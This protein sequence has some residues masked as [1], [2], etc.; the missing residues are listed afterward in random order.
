MGGPAAA[1]PGDTMGKVTNAQHRQTTEWVPATTED[2]IALAQAKLTEKRPDQFA[3]S[4]GS[5]EV[6]RAAQDP[7]ALPAADPQLAELAKNTRAVQN[8]GR[9]GKSQDSGFNPI[10][11]DQLL[12]AVSQS[13][14]QLAPKSLQGI[15][16]FGMLDGV[17][18]GRVQITVPLNAGKYQ[19][20]GHTVTVKPGTTA[21][22]NVEVRDG[23]VVP[24]QGGAGTQVT[25]DPPI[26]GPIGG[27]LGIRGKGAHVE[28]DGNGR[29]K[30]VA[31]VGGFIG[32]FVDGK[33]VTK[34]TD[35]G[36][37]TG[38]RK[39]IEEGSK[40]S[41]SSA[42]L[43]QG[44][45]AW[46]KVSFG[47]S[48]VTLRDNKVDLGS[49]KVDLGPDSK[50]K[51][52]GNA[53]KA[54]LTGNINID[55]LSLEQKG[56]QVSGGAGSANI[57]VTSERT[58]DGGYD[59]N[60]SLS[61]VQADVTSLRATSQS[62]KSASDDHLELKGAKLRDGQVEL[63]AHLNPDG[64]VASSH[65]RTRGRVDADSG[66]AQLTVP[67]ANGTASLR[68][69][70][71]GVSTRIDAS[72]DRIK[73]DGTATG[74]IE[75]RGLQS[76]NGSSSID[77][78]HARAAGD[79]SLNVDTAQ[80]K[81]TSKI[82]A[83]EID[84]RLDDYRGKKDGLSADIGRTEVTGT[85]TLELDSKK[86][87]KATGDMQV[88]GEIDD[89]EVRQGGKNKD[90]VFRLAQGSKIDGRIR[91]L[92]V[93]EANGFELD[94]RV[95]VDAKL[96]QADVNLPGIRGQGDGHLKGETDLK[97]G[98][99]EVRF[100]NA[101]ARATLNIKDGHLA[102]SGDVFSADLAQGKM[103]LNLKQ[104]SYSSKSDRV[105][106]EV[107]KGSVVE[108]SLDSG[109]LK[110]GDYEM[111]LEKGSRARMD[112]TGMR[113][114]SDGTPE[115]RG[116]L[117]L[118]TKGTVNAHGLEGKE[119]D[120]LR[121]QADG[122]RGTT[123]VVVDEV[124]LSQAGE[125]RM[126]GVS[127]EVAGQLGQIKAI[128]TSTPEAKPAPAPSPKTAKEANP[129]RPDLQ[130][131]S[132]AGVLSAEKAAASSAADLLG[133]KVQSHDLDGIELA[134]RVKNGT[135]DV[136]V[137]LEGKVPYKVLGINVGPDFEKG[138][139][140]RIHADVRDGEVVTDTLK[141]ELTKPGSAVMGAV[142]LEGVYL[143]KDKQ[144]RLKLNGAGN[145]DYAPDIAIADMR[146]AQEK[147]YQPSPFQAELGQIPER[148]PATGKGPRV[149]DFVTELS[150]FAPSGTSSGP[151]PVKLGQ[152]KISV[153]NAQLQDG[154]ELNLPIGKLK[155][156]ETTRLQINRDKDGITQL[157]GQVNVERLDVDGGAFALK[158]ARG[159]AEL[160]V[161][162]QERDHVAS[163]TTTLSKVDFQADGLATRTSKAD[164]LQVGRLETKGGTITAQT[165]MKIEDDPNRRGEK[166]YGEATTTF[167]AN[168]P[169][170][171]AQLASA[172][173]SVP[174]KGDERP[175]VE[176][177]KTHFNG[178]LVA[179]SDGVQRM[180]GKV[181]ELDAA[182][183]QVELTTGEGA[184][185][186]EAGRVK[187]NAEIDYTPSRFVAK[188]GNVEVDAVVDGAKAQLDRLGLPFQRTVQADGRIRVTGA[189]K[190][191][192]EI[193]YAET[194]AAK[195]K[196]EF[197]LKGGTVTGSGRVGDLFGRFV[198]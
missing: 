17:D 197:G 109:L 80:D 128:S 148:P 31:D 176:L 94:A 123:K 145:V 189:L 97:I 67:D 73:L 149:S 171:E 56:L 26:D 119:R 115:L 124:A 33:A 175:Q 75:V 164:Y 106:M 58:K 166:K 155:V 82:K 126:K 151:S 19:V 170:L 144:L 39:M 3:R 153:D 118:E 95:K 122:N 159:T 142:K 90:T 198:R 152:A 38:V 68:V 1:E 74:E 110:S 160:N 92:S 157:K 13:A 57:H 22:V 51:L 69:G 76:K 52:S 10:Q 34:S 169:Q 185:K 121:V 178:A 102:P 140:L 130:I 60:A 98:R 129:A 77:I 43:P 20:D 141:A 112:I 127:F 196:T 100:E 103:E 137:P 192:E 108:A 11:H 101:D 37:G 78:H 111:K 125:L 40:S 6:A 46:D 96:K 53:Q 147:A 14:Q 48:D 165:T 30:V 143:D 120:G 62:K 91:Q 79:I 179:T 134:K 113:A 32:S 132:P 16:G 156:D 131:Q 55:Q 187:A 41:A 85:G 104:A 183:R 4:N 191:V 89:L 173:L 23:R 181:S 139:M 42:G 184:M 150:G 136:E 27:P 72:D 25:I 65:Y 70:A 135:L 84:V 133:V 146:S 54:E 15:D 99:G 138:S 116:R 93:D 195:A 9:G 158:N 83:S 194:N 61:K 8:A 180:S 193:S 2:A 71:K 44:M 163:I 186:I 29:G 182:M 36:L 172:R 5:S 12:G 18:K 114:S 59:V 117:E 28:A 35:L 47:A 107:G 64:S 188:R 154:T 174:P 161:T 86:G 63:Q 21:K 167:S 88:K 162:H 87:L 49:M 105:T 24:A 177:G 7:S 190:N 81:F 66:N 45:V 168:L 50:L